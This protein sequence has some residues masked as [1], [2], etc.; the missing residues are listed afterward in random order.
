MILIIEK[1]EEKGKL[2]MDS[3][4]GTSW[5]REE[6]SICIEEDV[7]LTREPMGMFEAISGVLK[8]RSL[9]LVK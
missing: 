2:K 8:P 9:G 6:Y 4:V 3:M 1:N 5:P 7:S